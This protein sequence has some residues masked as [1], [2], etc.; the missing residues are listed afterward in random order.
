MALNSN[1]SKICSPDYSSFCTESELREGWED[2]RLEAGR[3]VRRLVPEQRAAAG[4]E[5]WVGAGE[6]ICM[7]SG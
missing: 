6:D 4:L 3:P 1:Y 7:E 2:A 5:Q